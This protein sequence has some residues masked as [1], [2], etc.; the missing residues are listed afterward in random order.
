MKKQNISIAVLRALVEK[1]P[2]KCEITF[3]SDTN[4]V[5][6]TTLFGTDDYT[7]LFTGSSSMDDIVEG[8]CHVQSDKT[9]VQLNNVVVFDDM[10]EDLP[11]PNICEIF[12]NSDYGINLFQYCEEKFEDQ[13]NIDLKVMP[14]NYFRTKIHSAIVFATKS[15]N[16]NSN[17]VY[18][19][20]NFEDH[21]YI[22]FVTDGEHIEKLTGDF[23]IVDDANNIVPLQDAVTKTKRYELIQQA[24][25][26]NKNL[27]NQTAFIIDDSFITAIIANPCEISIAFDKCE[28][29]CS[30]DELRSINSEC[31][32]QFTFSRDNERDITFYG[33][34][35]G[36]VSSRSGNPPSKRW[37]SLAMYMTEAGTFVAVK[38]G[39]T[40][41]ED[42]QPRCTAKVVNSVD[43]IIEFYGYGRLSKQLYEKLLINITDII[44]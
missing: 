13:I 6:F 26:N 24:E 5:H 17:S 37:T 16:N 39:E 41:I 20:L 33:Y 22:S 31:L 10:G 21:F 35:L 23:K 12:A 32:D 43:E 4:C 38:L 9:Q 2:L 30:F 44:Q 40:D 8:L 15:K 14:L 3:D 25:N 1:D 19:T 7:I 29:V 34:L 18:V 36:S 27:F 42:E 28:T 11:N